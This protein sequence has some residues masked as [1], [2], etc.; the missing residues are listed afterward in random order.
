MVPPLHGDGQRFHMPRRHVDHQVADLSVRDGFEV[1]ANGV[2]VPARGE[3]RGG[4]DHVP[5]LRDELAQATARLLR[6]NRLQI[7][8]RD[9]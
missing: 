8:E 7:P 3:G 1:F 5:G 2:D 9:A 6:L 4:F